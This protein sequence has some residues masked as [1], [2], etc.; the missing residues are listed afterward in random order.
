MYIYEKISHDVAKYALIVFLIIFLSYIQKNNSCVYL[1]TV[2]MS[3]E[4]NERH[5]I[6]Y[7][8]CC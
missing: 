2:L 4:N 8:A 1:I 7:F 3:Y 6:Q 5:V